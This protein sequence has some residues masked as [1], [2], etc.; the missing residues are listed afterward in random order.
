[1]S[2]F[3]V[4]WVR[5]LRDPRLRLAPKAALMVMASYLPF[6]G[7]HIY[8]KRETLQADLGCARNTLNAAIKDLVELG[9]IEPRG[10]RT[11]DTKRKIEWTYLGGYYLLDDERD[12]LPGEA[13]SVAFDRNTPKSAPIRYI[14]K[15][16]KKKERA[17]VALPGVSALPD[18][19]PLEAWDAFLEM[20]KASKKP[21]TAYAKDLLLRRLD[22]FRKKG[23]D[24]KEL[25]DY[26][27]R[28]GYTDIWTPKDERDEPSRVDYARGAI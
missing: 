8:T 20:R 4:R 13:N 5:E 2:A 28:R 11:G 22:G 17:Q 15:E 19:L 6:G 27:T 18:W 21:A 9:Y 10:K 12:P 1:M 25:L 16:R 26:N 7:T 23:H 14:D 24:P 3:E